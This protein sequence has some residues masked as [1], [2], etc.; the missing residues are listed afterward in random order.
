MIITKKY[1]LSILFIT[2][3]IGNDALFGG[4]N[5]MIIQFKHAPESILNDV[6]QTFEKEQKKAESTN[7]A[8]HEALKPNLGGFT[9]LYGGYRSTTNKHGLISFPL[10]HPKDSV[11]VVITPAVNL[12]RFKGNT[13]E[14]FK[15][16]T[17]AKRYLFI[18]KTVVTK[19]DTAANAQ[20]PTT[21]PPPGEQQPGTKETHHWEVTEQPVKAGETIDE[22]SIIIVTNTNNIAVMPGKYMTGKTEQLVL[23]FV[24]YVIGNTDNDKNTL[25][26]LDT[27]GFFE[28]I[29]I[30][31]KSTGDE[32]DATKKPQRQHRIKN[33]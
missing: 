6:K 31:E 13:I 9:C 5:T 7:D 21:P 28:L 26:L 20:P 25:K 12:V 8:L 33:L 10:R 11:P 27:E 24:I 29:L 2:M 18:K 19:D 16:G 1:I 32:K 22:T 4:N 17:E 3:L 15:G 23:P 30:D 14:T